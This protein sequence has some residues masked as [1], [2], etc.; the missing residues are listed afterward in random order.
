M[1]AKSRKGGKRKRGSSRPKKLSKEVQPSKVSYDPAPSDAK[2]RFVPSMQYDQEEEAEIHDEVDMPSKAWE[3]SY[4][5]GILTLLALSPTGPGLVALIYIL[6]TDAGSL[7]A[8][9]CTTTGILFPILF[10]VC[11]LAFTVPL[12]YFSNKFFQKG[13]RAKLKIFTWLFIALSLVTL[14]L[15]SWIFFQVSLGQLKQNYD[16]GMGGKVTVG[17]GGGRGSLECPKCNRSFPVPEDMSEKVTCP[18]CAW[19]ASVKMG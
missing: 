7:S 12:W 15:I 9:V 14:N 17:T 16:A 10:F 8:S 13:D 18:Y 1:M 5:I 2:D 11:T 3:R 4:F 19:T 6:I